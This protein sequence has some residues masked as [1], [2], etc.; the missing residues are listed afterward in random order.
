M[1]SIR[2]QLL[3]AYLASLVLPFVTILMALFIGWLLLFPTWG[4]L[5]L[6]GLARRAAELKPV[7]EQQMARGG[8]RELQAWLER[9]RKSGLPDYLRVQVVAP[10][11]RLLGDT[12][13]PPHREVSLVTLYRWMEAPGLLNGR[14]HVTELLEGRDGS[15]AGILV[16]SAPQQA[17]RVIHLD[18][19]R[20]EDRIGVALLLSAPILALGGS[21]ALF[22]WLGS[23]LIRPIQAVS[24]AVSRVADGDLTVEVPV[25][26]RDEIGQLARSV[27]VMIRRLREAQEQAEAAERA[28]RYWV[29]AAS[30]DLR[31]PLTVITVQAEALLR[32]DLSSPVVRS[33]LESVQQKAGQIRE[34]VDS[35]FELAAMDAQ[36]MEWPKREAD[37]A[38]LVRRETAHL[39]PRIEQVGMALE[40]EVPETP[41]PVLVAADKIQ[42]AFQNLLQNAIRY[43]ASGQALIVRV[44]PGPGRTWR[45]EV[46]D[47][48]PGVDEEQIP[49]L[50][51]RFTRGGGSRTEAGS[52]GGLGLAILKEIVQRHGGRVGAHNV[53]EG[54]ACFWFELPAQTAVP[55]N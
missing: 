24:T 11:G 22:W 30:H 25:S 28:R 9:I 4:S 52:G 37:L 51:E 47:R 27:R 23:T 39:L 26:R 5:D 46:E 20:A 17:T 40:M 34:L 14:Y 15:P 2:A 43:G 10:D 55:E 38:E 36:T 16:V 41:C 21:V 12:D 29:A 45:V 19:E 18:G 50:F 3:L 33:K 1:G 7:V 49:W 35:L 13:G 44:R 6:G 48:G 53:P 54:G 8:P 31:T 32:M 42:R